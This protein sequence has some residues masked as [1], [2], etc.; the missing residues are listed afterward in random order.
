MS[1]GET[2][3]EDIAGG[4][5]MQCSCKVAGADEA[6]CNGNFSGGDVNGG[7]IL[8]GYIGGG[9]YAVPLD[10]N[11]EGGDIIGRHEEDITIGDNAP[12]N[13]NIAGEDV[14]LV[15]GSIRGGAL[16]V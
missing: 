16:L 7:N 14:A 8:G 2:L 15:A 4:D 1:Q 10:G 11:V 9:R 13:G 6:P 3:L 5:D 12:L